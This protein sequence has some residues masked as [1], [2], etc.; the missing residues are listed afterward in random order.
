MVIPTEHHSIFNL[1]KEGEDMGIQKEIDHEC[2]KLVDLSDLDIKQLDPD[3][4]RSYAGMIAGARP[5]LDWLM[6]NIIKQ[7]I[8]FW[9]RHSS[10]QNHDLHNG[11]MNVAD[12]FMEAVENLTAEHK[13]N[14]T[15]EE[16]PDPTT[17]PLSSGADLNVI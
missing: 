9:S 17:P 2:Y 1:A 16:K 12:L 11:G 4:R 13:E 15:P 10:T 14:T 7:Q 6:G 3:T 5:A 8:S